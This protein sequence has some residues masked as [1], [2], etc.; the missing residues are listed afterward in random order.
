MKMKAFL[1]GMCTM[2]ISHK[3]FNV[4]YRD[5]HQSRMTSMNWKLSNKYEDIIC[6]MSISKTQAQD[7]MKEFKKELKRETKKKIN[8]SL[9]TKI[10]KK[11]N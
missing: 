1:G 3:V 11:I 5:W 8:A 7:Y 4:L 9:W 2:F 6:N 10:Y